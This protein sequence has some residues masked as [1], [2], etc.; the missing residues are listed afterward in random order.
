MNQEPAASAPSAAAARM[1]RS[2][3][4]RRQGDVIVSLEVRPN[5]ISNLVALGWIVAPDRADK[6]ALS[7]AL[8]DLIEQAMAMRVTK[9]TGSEG[10]CYAPLRA[11]DGTIET[12]VDVSARLSSNLGPPGEHAGTRGLDL[13]RV[14]RGEALG[15]AGGPTEIVA[16]EPQGIQPTAKPPRPFEVD[17][18]ELWGPRLSLYLRRKLWM[19]EWGARPGQM[20][21]A[22]PE[23][24]LNEYSIRPSGLASYPCRGQISFSRIQADGALGRHRH[25]DGDHE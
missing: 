25:S 8:V 14:K 11:T 22:A 9:S 23:W 17:P 2:R 7:R 10:A 21:C 15:A 6:D 3:D 5:E 20:G 1:R 16:D 13:Q 19:P 12:E 24:L 4:R 18:G